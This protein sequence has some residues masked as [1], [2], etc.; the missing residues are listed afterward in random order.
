MVKISKREAEILHE[1]YGVRYKD[2]GISSTVATGKKKR[3]YLCESRENMKALD[4]IRNH[5]DS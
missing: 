1:K 5:K 2:N 3:Y 4:K